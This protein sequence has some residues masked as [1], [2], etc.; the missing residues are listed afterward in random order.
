MTKLWLVC[1]GLIS[2]S[3]TANAQD[4]LSIVG[5]INHNMY[6]ETETISGITATA[7]GSMG[8]AGGIL[9]SHGKLEIGGI[10][11]FKKFDFKVAGVTAATADI[12][13]LHIPVMLRSTTGAATLGAGAFYDKPLTEGAKSNYG[14][15]A[16]TR[17]GNKLFLDLRG[18]YGLKKP[19]SKDLLILL[20]FMI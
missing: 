15:T 7:E 9:Y 19:A 3:V 4:R 13:W 8:Q 18:N 20:G 1:V 2:A 11:L 5:G 16:S 17:F 12:N 10:V 6:S 14:V